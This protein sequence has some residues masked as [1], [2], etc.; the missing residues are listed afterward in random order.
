MFDFGEILVIGG[1]ALVVLG[2]ERL[3]QTARTIGQWVGRLQQQVSQMKTEFDRE[4]HLAD[5]RRIGEEARSGAQS[6][7]ASVRGAV[8]GLKTEVGAVAGQAMAPLGDNSWTGGP[9]PPE[10][11]F[12]RRYRPRPTIDDLTREVERLKRQMAVPDIAPGADRRR[13][14]RSRI[15]RVRIRR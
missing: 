13:A 3:P 14:P 10:A 11:S 7:E 6:V 2:P 8:S 12:A 4:F 9:P 15:N 1:V 5:L